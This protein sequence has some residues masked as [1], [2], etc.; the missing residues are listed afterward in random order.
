MMLESTAASVPA[1][2]YDLRIDSGGDGVIVS[3]AA[4]RL[5]F[6]VPVEAGGPTGFEVEARID[7]HT[8]APVSLAAGQH[9][10]V[11]WPWT[12]LTSGQ[13]V[14]WR[15]RA[16]SA[17]DASPW[18]EWSA[19]ECGL[20]DADWSAEW[21]SP[22][23]HDDPGYGARGAHTLARTFDAVD[24]VGARLYST[25]LGV[26]TA[27][28]NGQRVGTAELSPGSTS[29]DRTIYAQAADVTS[30]LQDGDNALEIEL[31]DGWYRGQVGAFRLPAGWGTTL[32]ARAE[33]HLELADGSRRV[34]RTDGEWTSAPSS[35]VRADLMDGQTTDFRAESGSA[36]PVIV[37][38]VD[39]PPI[40]WS[41]AP[42]VRVVETRDVVSANRIAEDTWVLDFGQNASGW[43]RLTDLGPAGTRTVIDY[44][45]H[46][47]QDGD[48]DTSH[49]DSTKPGEPSVVFVQHDEVVSAG[50][51][52]VF[53][54]RHTVHGFQYARISRERASF[55]AA[56]AQMRI[57]Q[58]DLRRTASF[59]SSA[60][61]L[62]RL[63]E[64]ADWSFRGNAVDVPTDCPTR[65][66]LAWTG[67]YQVF[68][69]TAAR[70]YDVL[71][72]TRKWL[73]SVRDD[74]LDDG[75]IA[76]FSPDGRRIKLNLDDQFAM[77]TGSSGWGDAI[78]FVPWEM[79]T[80][81]GD[82]QILEENWDA[83]V[84]WVEWALGAA[85]TTRHHS[86]VERSAEPQP[87]EEYLWDGTF[88]WG[89]WTEPV[90]KAEDGSRLDPIKTNPMAWFM[91]DKGEVGTAYLYRSTRILADAATVLGRAEDAERYAVLADRILDAWRTEFLAGDG[92]TV[93]DTQAAYVRALTFGLIPESQRAAA[94]E[95]LVELIRAAG[96]HLGTGFLA[97]GDLLPALADTG[98]ASVAYELLFQRSAPSWLH[99]IDRGATTVWEDWEGVDDEGAAHESLNHYS[100]GAVIR[101]LHTHAL[102]LRQDPGS[103]AWHTFTIAPV[104]GGGL[105]WATGHLDTPRGRIRVEW[106]IDGDELQ[107]EAE[108]PAGSAATVVFPDGSRHAVLPGPFCGRGHLIAQ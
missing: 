17:A 92:R 71:G 99:M 54:P 52:E 73:R 25:A 8:R 95:R 86:R 77:M 83:M 14:H 79:Y 2:P 46:I 61:A 74:Q 97:T 48:L 38:A 7:G 81:Y 82:S 32:A 20:L 64:I 13:R 19:F 47:G 102:G 90:P 78:T 100:K 70:L 3:G 104:L 24:I 84:R 96:T 26:Y 22:V 55:D 107:I 93:Q 50:G 72:F 37:G 27:S 49:L 16:L 58:T 18:S 36:V 34:I 10:L 41:P 28:I 12:A 69:P 68:A 51:G 75:R 89:E 65:E 105:T 59:E 11:P 66:R 106:R 29:Y 9:L 91:A 85:R 101:F 45:E 63:H 39:G 33:L 87:H 103:V 6:T 80:A 40:S 67:D 15:V 60:P 76:N 23:E 1:A 5:S 88:H 53:E 35:I 57:V 30:L 43:I 98:H 56:T 108:V 31:S 42:P 94:A 21:I 44:G 4:P 62:N